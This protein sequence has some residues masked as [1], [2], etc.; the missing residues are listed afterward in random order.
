MVEGSLYSCKQKQKHWTV[1]GTMDFDNIASTQI[2]EGN[3]IDVIFPKKRKPVKRKSTTAAVISTQQQQLADTPEDSPD[4]LNKTAT[5]N[6]TPSQFLFTNENIFRKNPDPSVLFKKY[7]P[8]VPVLEF[9]VEEL[10]EINDLYRS[11]QD[12]RAGEPA[13][14]TEDFVN[15]L[16]VSCPVQRFLNNQAAVVE[17]PQLSTSSPGFGTQTS[18]APLDSSSIGSL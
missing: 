14:L 11:V 8:A 10:A 15:D 18:L 3:T 7:Y 13:V 12:Q 9:T 17:S 2:F 16:G 6:S 4:L 1:L 5:Q